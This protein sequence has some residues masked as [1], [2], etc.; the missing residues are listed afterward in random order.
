MFSCYHK[1]RIFCLKN[2]LNK[3]KEVLKNETKKQGKKAAKKII[4]K[5]LANPLT[6][7]LLEIFIIVSSVITLLTGFLRIIIGY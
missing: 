7:K 3:G 5:I 4:I 2:Q 6:W 1:S